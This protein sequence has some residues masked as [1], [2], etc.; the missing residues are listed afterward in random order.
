MARSLNVA[1]YPVE[2]GE[3]IETLEGLDQ[4]YLDFSTAKEAARYRFKMYGYTSA[5]EYAVEKGSLSY[6]R[7]LKIIRD[8][9]L[10]I[11]G[12]RLTFQSYDT[13][14]AAMVTRRAIA[15]L[16]AR[17][18]MV[19]PL[20]QKLKDGKDERK[21]LLPTLDTGSTVDA[22]QQ[23]LEQLGYSPTSANKKAPAP[24][25]PP[26]LVTPLLKGK[27]GGLPTATEVRTST[28]VPPTLPA[29]LDPTKPRTPREIADA[30]AAFM[31][32]DSNDPEG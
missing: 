7:Q 22:T 27:E 18:G 29:P 23:M 31:A 3:L 5:L 12:T 9:S 6:E 16:Q 28:A 10:I 2:L 14:E 21:E 30:Y 25:A 32:R 26:S 19:D 1:R 15:D 20:I 4:Y 13:T 24:T 11:V 17:R 8:F